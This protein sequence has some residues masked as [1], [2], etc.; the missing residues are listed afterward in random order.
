ML[1]MTTY[2]AYPIDTA[3]HIAAPAWFLESESDEEVLA[4]ARELPHHYPKLEI[5]DGARRLDDLI[6]NLNLDIAC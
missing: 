5:W 4:R 1:R 6:E 2:R 3:G